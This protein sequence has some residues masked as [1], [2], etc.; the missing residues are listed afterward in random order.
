MEKHQK[1][2][3]KNLKKIIAY[4]KNFKI[5]AKNDHHPLN[6]GNYTA[7]YHQILEPGPLVPEKSQKHKK[8]VIFLK[9]LKFVISKC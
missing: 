7:T 4:P 5:G 6:P 9:L 1:F 2:F 3:K 8:I